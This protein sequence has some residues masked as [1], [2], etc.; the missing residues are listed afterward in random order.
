M[1]PAI[2]TTKTIAC[3][4]SDTFPDTTIFL[5]LSN[6]IF[7][8]SCFEFFL[9]LRIFIYYVIAHLKNSEQNKFRNAAALRPQ[10]A[11][12]DGAMASLRPRVSTRKR[13]TD[14]SVRIRWQST[15]GRPP[16]TG[17]EYWTE[18][19]PSLWHGGGQLVRAQAIT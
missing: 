14:R 7:F 1:K 6:E 13:P 15:A 8:L 4:P 12:G 17:S 18:I 16:S 9:G 10:Q 2:A 5:I 3:S 19:R 11:A